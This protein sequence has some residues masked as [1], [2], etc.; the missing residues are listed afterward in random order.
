MS[1]SKITSFADY[2]VS[3]NLLNNTLVDKLLHEVEASD[4]SFIAAL[5]K[6]EVLE[7]KT[8][9]EMVA[10]YFNLP[11]ANL[12]QCA[13]ANLP[14]A[15]LGEEFIAKYRVLPLA[16]SDRQLRLAVADPTCTDVL[17]KIRF[18]T[19]M[20]VQLVIVDWRKLNQLIDE[21]METKRYKFSDDLESPVI[22]FIND[23]LLAAIEKNASD[24]HFEPYEKYCRVRLRIDGLLH[25]IARVDLSLAQ[26]FSARLKVMANLNIAERRLPQ[27]GRFHWQATG[28]HKRDCRISVC[29]TLF[30]EKVVVRILQT[31]STNLSIL[32]LGFDETEQKIFLQHIN[33]PEGMILVTGPTGSGK[34]MS[35]Y[36]ALSILNT[37]VKNISTV[38]DPIEINLTGIN[39]V[40]VNNKIGLTFAAVLRAF[41]R[42]DP[43]VIMVGEIRD[44]ETAEI[45]IKAAQTGHLVLATLHTNSA[46]EAITRLLNMGIQA[47][48]LA[49]SIS[50]VIAQRLV[51][52]LCPYCKKQQVLADELLRASNLS[53]SVNEGVVYSAVGCDRCNRGYKGRVGIFE[54]LPFTTKLGDILLRTG[55]VI[56]IAKQ[57][58]NAGMRTLRETAIYKVAQG[59]TSLEE[60]M[61]VI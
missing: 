43:D 30:G 49:G 34:T 21:L 46:S 40:A 44:F 24:V 8:I 10:Q 12:E 32:E 35:L 53:M 33:R 57:A 59:V 14:I 61:R 11:L 38:E 29:P 56:E 20:N 47:F 28:N 9:A 26:R 52:K 25:E 42:Q 58:K 16:H 50:L 3:N 13:V 4:K 18:H 6:A 37:E 60:V 51:R 36:T 27:D 15:T 54:V 19:E 55:N 22:K 2:L 39:Q 41:L 1:D 48:N 5:V 45:A 7:T 23:I 17:S 31:D